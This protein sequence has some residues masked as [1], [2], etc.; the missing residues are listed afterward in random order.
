M[1]IGFERKEIEIKNR[2]FIYVDMN[3]FWDTGLGIA[4]KLGAVDTVSGFFSGTNPLK[5]IKVSLS[6]SATAAI[7]LL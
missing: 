6:S 4:L 2:I 3:N 7:M 1:A 5:F